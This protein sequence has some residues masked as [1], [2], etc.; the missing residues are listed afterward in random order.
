M[1]NRAWRSVHEILK[2]GKDGEQPLWNKF[3]FTV[4]HVVHQVYVSN[5][6]ENGSQRSS[7]CKNDSRRWYCKE[8]KICYV[9]GKWMSDSCHKMKYKNG[10]VIR[11]TMDTLVVHSLFLFCLFGLLILHENLDLIIK[12]YYQKQIL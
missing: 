10:K 11:K 2:L 5:I 3:K 9:L 6:T 8:H 4:T 12:S 7:S 1:E